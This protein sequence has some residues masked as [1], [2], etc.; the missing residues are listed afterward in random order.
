MPSSDVSED[1]DIVLT[2]IKYINLKLGEVVG[3]ESAGLEQEKEKK[4]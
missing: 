4:Q 3:S 2:Y 1:S